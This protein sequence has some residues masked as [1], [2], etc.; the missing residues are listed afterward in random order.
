M[1]VAFEFLGQRA[2]TRRFGGDA[3]DFIG[4]GDARIDFAEV[5]ID[6]G[7]DRFRRL[8]EF[9]FGGGEQPFTIGQGGFDFFQ[10]LEQSDADLAQPF[11]FHL[12]GLVVAFQFAPGPARRFVG[13]VG[14]G[15]G[16]AFGE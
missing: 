14:F 12:V 10:L 2:F 1:A 4:P 3:V 11:P 8:P 6:Q 5:P 7:G 16:P 15:Q 9:G 13:R